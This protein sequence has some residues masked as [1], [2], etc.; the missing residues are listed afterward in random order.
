MSEDIEKQI[1][2]LIKVEG[3]GRVTAQKLLDKN[4]PL[5]RLGIIR[6]EEVATILGITEKKARDMVLSAK[7]FLFGKLEVFTGASYKEWQD[8]NIEWLSTGSTE[9]DKVLGGGVKTMNSYGLGG[10]ASTGKSQMINQVIVNCIKSG[11]EVIYIETES[12]TF[13]PKRLVEMGGKDFPLEKILLIPSTKIGN[14]YLQFTAYEFARYKAREKNLKPGL[15]AIDSFTAKFRRSYGDRSTFPDR[16][17]EMGRHLD[18]L[19]DM[20]KEFNAI[21]MVTCQVGEKPVSPQ[22]QSLEKMRYGTQYYPYGG[23]ILLH[24]LNFWLSLIQ[25]KTDV[26]KAILWDSSEEPRGNCTFGID[27]GGIIN[28]S[29]LVIK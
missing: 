22:E 13:S 19:E 15:I 5:E 23:H 10:P 12:G 9:L 24:T 16:A 6:P 2:E 20:T 11:R 1:E 26:Y 4:V 29:K 17:R 14:P 8:E 18:Y 3:V 28:K 27:K 25:V 7:G 21:L